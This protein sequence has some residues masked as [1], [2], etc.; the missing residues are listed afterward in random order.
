M[1]ARIPPAS[2]ASRASHAARTART[3]RTRRVP[4]APPTPP[5]PRDIPDLPAIPR[6]AA[7]TPSA[8]PATA[9]VAPTRRRRAAA[10]RLLVA[11]TTAAAVAVEIALGSPARVLSHF[12]VQSGV[13]AALVLA[14]SARRA[15]TARHPLPSGVTGAALLYVTV[16]ALA[17]H[18]LLPRGAP[19]FSFTGT[20]GTHPL[21]QTAA[22]HVLTTATPVAALLD[23]LLLTAPARL[24]LRQAGPWLLYPL[25]YLAFTLTR[26]ELLPPGA[27]DRYLYP[28]LTADRHGY[29]HVLG[30]ALL[31]SLSVYALA[32]LLV[33]VDH[34]RPDPTHHPAKTGFRLQ[35][36]VG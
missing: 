36:P 30:N 13:F 14:L 2:R 25:A 10:Y 4:P 34:A 11:A 28:F 19:S 24:H 17:H 8:V 16:T 32:L 20:P 5:I 6:L 21:W 29:E 15:W 7:L 3:A 33:A 35:P 23:W 26:A 22:T 18:L 9:V 31:L 27:P 1:P 12:A